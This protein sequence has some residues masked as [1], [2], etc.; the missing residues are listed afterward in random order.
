M[1]NRI[2]FFIL[3]TFG[4]LFFP[5]VAYAHCPLC[6][7]GAGVIAGTAA[8]LGV[9]VLV[10]GVV[11]GGFSWLLG[12]WFAKTLRAKLGDFIAA[13]D[14]LLSAIIYLTIIIPVRLGIEQY[15]SFYLSIAGDYGTFLNRTYVI[16]SF[17]LG[18]VIGLLAAVLALPVSNLISEI[19]GESL[20]FQGMIS[21]LFILLL[22]AIVTWSLT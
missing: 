22:T 15:V 11:I 21:T 19:R 20:R 7:L 4:L 16:N 6:T 10:V 5:T 13:Q 17:L 14:L 3:I 9:D 1:I 8:Y 12:R 18:S 2:K